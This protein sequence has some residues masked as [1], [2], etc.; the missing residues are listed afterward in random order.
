MDQD[1]PSAAA[2]SLPRRLAALLYDSVLLFGL[3]MLAVWLLIYP[4]ELIAGRPYPNREPLYRTFEQLYLL[5]VA[6]GFFVYFWTHGGQTLGMRTWRFKL[7]R[8]DGGPLGTRDALRRLGWAALG[9]APAGLGLLW[10]LVDPQ[11]L[12]WYDRRSRTRP[13]RD[14]D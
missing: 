10:C 4:F 9:L 14:P 5:A 6:T 1:R 3:L 13:V 11:G 8:E 12:A 2:P 7:V